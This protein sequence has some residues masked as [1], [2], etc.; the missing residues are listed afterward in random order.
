MLLCRMFKKGKWM[1]NIMLRVRFLV[2]V[3]VQREIPAVGIVCR[4]VVRPEMP[5]FRAPLEFFDTE[6]LTP[7]ALFHSCPFLP[8][9]T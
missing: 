4:T 8:R 7:S 5:A 1:Q 2:P 9:G 6:E 3:V